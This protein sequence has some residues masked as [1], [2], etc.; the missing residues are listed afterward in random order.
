L[1]FIKWVNVYR[2]IEERYAGSTFV[3]VRPL[4]ETSDLERGAFLRPDT[5]AG[6]RGDGVCGAGVCHLATSR[7]VYRESTPSFM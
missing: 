6:E 2:Y 5:L 3:S 1:S 7:S 4:N